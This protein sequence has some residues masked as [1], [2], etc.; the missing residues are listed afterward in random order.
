MPEPSR[1]KVEYELRGKTLTVYLYLLRHGKAMGVREIQKELGFSSPSVAFHHLD[2][3]VE[4]GV[5]EKDQYD[6]YVLAKKVDTGILHSF[7]SIAGLTLPRLGFYAAFFTTIAA[8]YLLADRAS[9]DLYA[10]IGTVGGAAIFWY[11]AWRVWRR[12][13]F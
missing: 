10:L 1:E 12:K 9:L 7:V 13:P 5:V 8:A 6:R 2:K 11:E 4:L 3:L